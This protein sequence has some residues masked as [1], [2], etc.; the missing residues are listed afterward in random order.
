[1]S[2]DPTRD[3][4]AADALRFLERHTYA[5]PAA[6]TAAVHAWQTEHGLSDHEATPLYEAA[7][8]H[9]IERRVRQAVTDLIAAGIPPEEASARAV[10]QVSL[11]T[12]V[13]IEAARRTDT[14]R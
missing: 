14:E 1:M 3:Q 4:R 6:A 12:S 7:P 8:K 5:D 11:S 13:A 2:D 10:V 9:V